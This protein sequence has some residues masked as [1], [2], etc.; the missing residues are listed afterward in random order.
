MA[1]FIPDGQAGSYGS[2]S[3]S[4]F[5]KTD[6]QPLPTG[7]LASQGMVSN[8][9]NTYGQALTDIRTWLIGAPTAGINWIGFKEGT[10][11]A[12]TGMGGVGQPGYVYAKSSDHTL[13]SKINGVDTA[14]AALALAATLT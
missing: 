9:W 14:L 7:T 13:H 11:P 6:A 5:P 2:I 12:P 8:D 10:D 4:I 1:Q 3:G